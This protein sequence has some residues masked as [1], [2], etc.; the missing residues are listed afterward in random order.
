[1]AIIGQMIEKA[2]SFIVCDATSGEKVEPVDVVKQSLRWALFAI[3]ENGT[4]TVIFRDLW[5][6]TE[7]LVVRKQGLYMIK[8]DD[9]RCM[10]W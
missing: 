6:D 3:N 9:G 7:S 5:D 1:M 2:P 10:L 4:L 8:F